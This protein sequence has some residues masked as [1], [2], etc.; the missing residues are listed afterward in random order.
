MS[1]ISKYDLFSRQYGF[2]SDGDL[3]G[4]LYDLI[5]LDNGRKCAAVF[6][7]LRKAFDTV[8]HEMLLISLDNLGFRG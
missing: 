7:D 6:I 5:A 4:A 2:R 8:N 1:F 3:T